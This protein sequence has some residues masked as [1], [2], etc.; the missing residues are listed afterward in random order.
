MQTH[1]NAPELQERADTGMTSIQ[2]SLI[3]HGSWKGA[4]RAFNANTYG[5]TMNS[6]R[7][8]IAGVLLASLV[9]AHCGFAQE[10]HRTDLGRSTPCPYPAKLIINGHNPVT[11]IPAEFPPA[12]GVAVAGS[13]FSQTQIN[14]TFG[15]TFT[16]PVYPKECCLWTTGYLRVTFKALRGGSGDSSTSANDQ[17][18]IYVNGAAVVSSQSIWDGVVATNAV[19]TT[20]LVVPGSSLTHGHVSLTVKNRT[21]V[22]SAQLTL[23]GCCLCSQ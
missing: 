12:I 13:M 8:I 3:Q 23:E 17:A 19:K 22:L 20:T 16:F 10:E 18:A 21:A 11:V 15:Y 5:G 4:L 14:K 7:L 1:T 2:F 6:G 9:A